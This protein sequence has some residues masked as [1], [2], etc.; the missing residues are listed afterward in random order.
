MSTDSA[1]PFDQIS[2]HLTTAAK[3]LDISE[4]VLKKLLT[5]QFIRNEELDVKTSKGNETFE[6]YRIQYNNARGPF[7]GGIRFHPDADE[8]EVSALAAAMAVKCAVVDI[9]FGGAKGG[10]VI[11]PKQYSSEDLELVSR[12]YVQA[13]LPY[14]GI[15]VDIPAPDVY[16]NA[17]VMAWMLDEFE[18]ATGQNMPGF[19][20]GKPIALGGSLGRDTATAQGSVYVFLE[21]AANNKI[22]LH[23]LRVAIQG[24][25]NAGATVAKI[26][27]NEGAK[28]VSIS[29][30]KGTISCAE[31]I[32]P[33][34]LEEFKNAARGNS[35]IDF[36][37]EG[38]FETGESDVVLFADCDLLIPA[39]L[40]NVI[41]AENVSQIK[42]KT[43]L[44][45]ANNPT[46]PEAEESLTKNGVDILPDVL[47]NAGGVAVSYFEWVQ[48]RQQWYWTEEVVAERLKAKMIS[49][50]KCVNVK[51]T[52]ENSY[53][54]AAYIVG[55]E[56]L[57]T[58]ISLRSS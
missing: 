22:S 50:F 5:P 57:A 8:S 14:L 3:S 39:A 40:D 6:A 38:N 58:A 23:G 35:V 48:N 20:T 17:Q 46:T 33:V 36:K 56:R 44:E 2:H 27:H 31:G 19:I 1:N 11:D 4:K 53:R 37:K 12:A 34:E 26:L 51:K 25:G 30:S 21:Y 52:A 16:T 7:K 32:D 24:F 29:D 43:I 9:P 15:D 54:Q 49:A 10:V 55:V 18:Q 45:L 28:I 47:V 41:T 42:A 13:F